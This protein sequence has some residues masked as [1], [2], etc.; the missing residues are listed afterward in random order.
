MEEFGGAFVYAMPEGRI[1]L[2]LV[3]G[4]D[5]RDP[6]F[7]PYVAFQ[8][9][10]Q[11]P[12]IADLLARRAAREVRRQGAARRRLEHASRSRGWTAA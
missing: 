11:H 10:K 6:L 12:L 3:V 1:S 2:G 5:Y 8:R 9:L 4:L 7:D